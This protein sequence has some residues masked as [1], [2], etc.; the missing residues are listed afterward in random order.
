MEK[1][2]QRSPHVKHADPCYLL[3]LVKCICHDITSQMGAHQA[4]LRAPGARGAA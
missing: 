4:R 1:A 2:C 3:D